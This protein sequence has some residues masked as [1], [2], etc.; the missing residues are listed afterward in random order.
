MI[1]EALLYKGTVFKGCKRFCA[2]DVRQQYTDL[3]GH[4]EDIYIPNHLDFKGSVVCFFD[5]TVRN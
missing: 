2:K 5:K 3:N 1:R 4:Y